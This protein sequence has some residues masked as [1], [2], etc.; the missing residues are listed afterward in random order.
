MTGLGIG[1]AFGLLVVLMI[2]VFMVRQVSERILDRGSAKRAAEIAAS[3]QE[4]RN[5]A[6]AAVAAV[7]ALLSQREATQTG[8]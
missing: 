4:A 3:A 6:Q 1:T 2:L 5:K 7:T 8:R